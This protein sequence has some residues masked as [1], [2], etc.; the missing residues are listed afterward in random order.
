MYS[1]LSHDSVTLCTVSG[2]SYLIATPGDSTLDTFWFTTH[3]TFFAFEVQ[4]SRDAT[5][6]FHNGTGFEYEVIIG[7]EDNRKTLIRRI[8]GQGHTTEVETPNILNP[9]VPRKFWVDNS[10]E[11]IRVGRGELYEGLIVQELITPMIMRAVAITS[12]GVMAEWRVDQQDGE[13]ERQKYALHS[14]CDMN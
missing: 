4:A 14:Q 3:R 10:G 13:S 2:Q 12:K 11:E 5:I 7:A 1:I 6:S 9:A 8:D